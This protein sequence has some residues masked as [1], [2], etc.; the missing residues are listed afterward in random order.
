MIDPTIHTAALLAIETAINKAL[1]LD[2]ATS[3]RLGK[4]AGNSYAIDCT[5]LKLSVFILLLNDRL[6][7]RGNYDDAVT[8]SLSG[9]ISAYLELFKAEDKASALINS[10]LKLKGS[11]Q[12][13]MD[14]QQALSQLDLDWEAQI[15]KLIGDVPSHFLGQ[16]ARRLGEFARQSKSSF[17]RHLEEFILE[18]GR[19][20]PSH[21]EADPFFND[22]VKL[23]QDSERLEARIGRLKQQLSTKPKP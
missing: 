1:A 10:E 8:T 5:E 11:T 16:G 18:E 17:L 22:I 15:S 12:A 6:E 2:P 20:S 14:L 21:A 19:L 23:K 4:L 3:E 13:V 7:L 9:P